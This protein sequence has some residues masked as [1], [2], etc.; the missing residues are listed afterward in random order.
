MLSFLKK[1]RSDKRGNVL[2]IASAAFPLLVGAA[3]LATDT[4]QWTLWKRQLQRAADSAALAGV[5][6]RVQAGD[7]T[8]VQNAV[9]RDLTI[10]NH[11]NIGL[12]A[13]YPKVDLPANSG[14]LQDQVHVQLALQKRLVFSSMFMSTPPTITANA[15]AAS[16]P[17]AGDACVNARETS[18]SKTGINITGN[19]GIYMPDCVMYSNSPASNSAAAGGSSNVTA[20]SVA[21]VGGVQQS[22]NWHVSA[23]RPYSPPVADPFAD[24]TPDPAD[25]KCAVEATTKKGVTTYTPLAADENTDYANAKDINGDPANCFT[26]LSIGSNKSNLHDLP[27]GP[28]Y[29]NGGDVFIQG[30]LTAT[31]GTT[32]VL[33]NKDASSPIGQFKVNADSNI[34]LTAPTT[35]DFQGIAVYQDRRATDSSPGNKINGNSGSVITGALYFPSQELDYNGSGNTTAVCTMF[36]ARRINFS[37]NSTTTNKFKTLADCSDEGL[38]SGGA[39]RMVRLVA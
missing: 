27:A 39:V 19:A 7:L 20:D 37:G 3:G 29:I 33:T 6:Q 25:M 34:N 12:L 17:A 26:S 2:F 18:G 9:A 24:V 11:T 16:V 10:N 1:L 35:G 23:Y 5:Y 36:V 32:I 21:T 13:T 14:D 28:L 15:T 30:D 8:A 4:I 31:S 38:P 22:N